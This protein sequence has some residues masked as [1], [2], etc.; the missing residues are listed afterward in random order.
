MK[1]S[2]EDKRLLD[3]QE[4]DAKRMS[5]ELLVKLGTIYGAEKLVPIAS[6][7]V[8]AVYPHLEASPEIMEKFSKAGGKF[9]VTTTVDPGHNENNFDKWPEFKEPEQIKNNSRRLVK[10]VEGMGCIPNW[11]C[12]PYYQGNLPRKGEYIAWTESSAISFANSVLGARTNRT[13]IGVDVASAITGRTPFFGLLLD[14]N[15]GGNVKIVLEKSPKTM[16]DFN[17]IGYIIGKKF[18]DK[19]PVI[20]GLPQTTTANQLKVMGAAAAS[21]GVVP[22]YHAL[23]ITPEAPDRKTAYREKKPQEEFVI[24][25]NEISEAED[26]ISTYKSGDIDAVLVGC[27]HPTIGELVELSRN[28]EN[29][30]VKDGLKFCLFASSDVLMLAK[31]MGLYKIFIECGVSIFEG[32]CILFCP[33]KTWGWKNIATNSAKYANLLPSDPTYF[34]VLFT[35]TKECVEIGT[36][37]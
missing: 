30:K 34:N 22:L 23:G 31:R 19:I 9:C 20:E 37:K 36:K 18:S 35:T 17:L 3:G 7:H 32:D 13:T 27:P 8:L 25:T 21:S 11:S 5:M 10:A 2:D 1:L 29:R 26:D 15:R 24:G 14:E 6:A 12:T 4:G 16:Y 28:L 33:A